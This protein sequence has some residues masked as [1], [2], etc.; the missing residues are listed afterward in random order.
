MYTVKG[1]IYFQQNNTHSVAKP[2][3]SGVGKTI[4]NFLINQILATQFENK[5]I[6]LDMSAWHL[7]ANRYTTKVAVNVLSVYKISQKFPLHLQS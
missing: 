4:S 6:Y 1:T 5:L 7:G 2:L 3:V